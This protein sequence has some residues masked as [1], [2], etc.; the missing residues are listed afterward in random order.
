MQRACNS[1]QFVVFAFSLSLS[2][3]LILSAVTRVLVNW[4]LHNFL[5]C[6]VRNKLLELPFRIINKN[7]SITPPLLP[8]N[9][10]IPGNIFLESWFILGLPLLSPAFSPKHI[11]LHLILPKLCNVFFF[12]FF[13]VKLTPIKPLFKRSSIFHSNQRSFHP[14][15]VGGLTVS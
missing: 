9:W 4:E 2:A 12:S 11:H 7:C 14:K 8:V 10:P 15:F 5:I 3:S 6:S 1:S 13:P